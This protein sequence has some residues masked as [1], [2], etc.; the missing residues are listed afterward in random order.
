MICT[1]FTRWIVSERMPTETRK[2][3]F[4][5]ARRWCRLSCCCCCWWWWRWCRWWWTDP[6]FPVAVLLS[7]IVYGC[8]TGS[9]WIGQLRMTSS[10]SCVC[11]SPSASVDILMFLRVMC[12]P[13]RA[14][15]QQSP[16][17]SQFI[18]TSDEAWRY[19]SIRKSHDSLSR[20]QTLRWSVWDGCEVGNHVRSQETITVVGCWS[21]RLF[22]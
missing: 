19:L 8:K 4:A 2:N 9:V 15:P 1:M 21:I 12:F 7:L 16:W 10:V 14:T 18:S 20:P 13:G 5:I 6:L 22:R 17:D 11:K 3:I